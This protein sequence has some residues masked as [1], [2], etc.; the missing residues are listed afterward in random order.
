MYNMEH[1]SAIKNSRIMS[2][3]ERRMELEIIM[4]TKIS[5]TQKDK[6]HHFCHIWN[7]KGKEG[8]EHK[9]GAFGRKY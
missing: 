9:R 1:Y 6:Y 2:S 4:F 5:Q 7:L 8:H 3:A